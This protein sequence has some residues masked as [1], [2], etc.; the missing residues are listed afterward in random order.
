MDQVGDKE[1]TNQPEPNCVR[2]VRVKGEA[3]PD[4]IIAEPDLTTS[5]VLEER[6]GEFFTEQQNAE[7]LLIK[8]GVVEKAEKYFL[9][10]I[11]K[12]E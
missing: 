9:P 2:Q 1:F 10:R 7:L 3:A 6:R 5:D 12:Q 8:R 4:V 11:M